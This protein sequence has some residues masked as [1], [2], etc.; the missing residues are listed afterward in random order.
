MELEIKR[1]LK[2]HK[3][4]IVKIK[5]VLDKGFYLA[6]G[7]AL[8]YYLN[9]RHSI[10]LDFFI[11]K[12]I[13]FRE[14]APFLQQEKIKLLS[15]DTIH[16]VVEN[17]N[18]SLFQY[19]YPLLKPLKSFEIIH[20]ASLED[21]LCMKVNAIIQRGSRKDFTDVYFIMKSLRLKSEDVISLFIQKYGK[22]DELVI[23]KGL[24]YFEDAEKEPEFSMI[25]KVRWSNVKDFFIKEFAKI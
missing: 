22:Y 4:A 20:L 24:T 5:D 6:G 18:I 12:K 16:A 10:D 14:F 11:N 25:R 15:K 17:V 21:I 1:L 2:K 8:F 23:K 9:H 3:K 13:D 7:T 19:L